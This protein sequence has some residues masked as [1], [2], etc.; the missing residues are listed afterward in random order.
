MDDTAW[1]A[2]VAATGLPLH[3]CT[4]ER[5]YQCGCQSEEE[6]ALLWEWIRT[7]PKQDGDA[8]A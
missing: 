8:D 3:T 6:R 1:I 7:Q 4:W 2:C 5:L